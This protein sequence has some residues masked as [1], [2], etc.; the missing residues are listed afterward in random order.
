MP[1]LRH[2]AERLSR[3]VTF[4][5]RLPAGFGPGRIVVSPDAGLRLLRPN[6]AAT[7]PLLFDAVRRLVKPGMKIWDIGA[8]LG[9]FGFAAAWMAGP[10][11]EVLLVE[12]DPWLCSVLQRSTHG[13]AG[14]GYAPVTLAACA[15]TDRAGPVRF[16]IAA[17]GRASNSIRGYGHSQRG[18]IRD[19]LVVGGCTA[20]QLLDDAFQPDLIKID[21]EGAELA[22]LRGAAGVLKTR[23]ALVLEVGEENADAVTDLLSQAGYRLH[24][25]EDGMRPIERCRWATVALPA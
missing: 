21:V 2:V 12:A 18:G 10:S 17:R 8:N 11:G 5:R 24:D 20:D 3:G 9:L 25:A 4:R 13:L 6:L 7:E 16:E 22:V 14:A 23:P 19:T 15:M 1:S